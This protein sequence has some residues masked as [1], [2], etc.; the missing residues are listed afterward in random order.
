MKVLKIHLATWMASVI[1]TIWV[2]SYIWDVWLILHLIAKSSAWV[3]VMI[4]WPL[5]MCKTKIAI[6]FLTLISNMIS[7]V[8][9]LKEE[10]S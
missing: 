4:S 1:M 5:H 6:L 3:L 8:F 7:T 9:W 10:F 2:I